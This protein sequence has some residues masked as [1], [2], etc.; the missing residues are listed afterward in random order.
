MG[1]RNIAAEV[2]KGLR[3]IREHC[4]GKRTLH[5]IRVQ[6]EPLASLTPGRIARIST[7]ACT[8]SS[9]TIRRRDPRKG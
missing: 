7:K 8:R 3:E 9:S 1:E 4:A 2:L 6:A 5:M